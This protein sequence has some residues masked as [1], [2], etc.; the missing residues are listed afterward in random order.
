MAG[1]SKS[2]GALT[3]LFGRLMQTWCVW[4][5]GAPPNARFAAKSLVLLNNLKHCPKTIINS[6]V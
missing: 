4:S 2:P 3:D 1:C 6:I 5:P